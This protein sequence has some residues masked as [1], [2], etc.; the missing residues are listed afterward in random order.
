MAL[1][2]VAQPFR[3]NVALQVS[4]AQQRHQIA[5][6]LTFVMVSHAQPMV[7]ALTQAM[8]FRHPGT[9]A[10]VLRVSKLLSE[11]EVER[12]VQKTIALATHVAMVAH[13]QTCLHR[14]RLLAH[15]HV[16]AMTVMNWWKRHPVSQLAE[17]GSAESF[18]LTP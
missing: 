10:R 5:V 7:L 8:V 9:P 15:T 17:E 3:L 4:L 11:Q 16:L 14:V 13:A 1:Q 2:L 18:L 6:I 12:N